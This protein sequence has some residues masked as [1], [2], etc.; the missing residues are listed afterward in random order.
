MKTIALKKLG[1]AAS[2]GLLFASSSAWSAEKLRYVVLVDGGKQAGEQVVETTDDGWTKVK[3]IFK[4]NGRGP[5]IEERYRLDKDGTFAEYYAKG[6]TTFGSSVD[7]S[8]V[9]K[10]TSAQWKSTAE[11]GSTTLKQPALYSPINASFQPAS[12]AI[13]LLSNSANGELN[14]L[15]GGTLRQS[16]VSELEVKK[17]SETRTIQLLKQTGQGLAPNFVWATKGKDA[18]LFAFLVPG[19]LTGIEEGWQANAPAMEKLQREAE[20]KVLKE[21]AQKA[22]KPLDGLAVIRNARVFDS[23]NAK[24]SEPSDVYVLRGVITS[25]MPANSPA[26]GVKYEV[27]A[28]GRVLLPGL[29]DMHGHV[30]QWD[31]AL[32][33]AAG[34]TTVRDMG[35]DNATLQRIMDQH[36]AGELLATHIVP[37]GFLEG[38]SP[39]SARNGFVI[40]NLQQAKDAI[41]WYAQHGYPQ[42]KIY[43]SFPKEILKETVEYAHSRGMRVSG[44]I[45]VFLR[46][47]DAVNA[48][49]DEI[50]HINQILLNFLVKPDTDTRT[51]ERFRLPADQ[52]ADLDFDS[53]PV[54]DYIALLKNKNVAVDPTLSTFEFIRQKDGVVSESYKDVIDHMPLELQRG[55]RSGSMKIPDE[56]TYQRYNKSYEKM[57]EFVGRMYK[58]GIPVVAGTDAISGFTLHSELEFYVKAGLTPAQ[59]LQIATLNGAKFSRT[60]S[61]RGQI[62]PGYL[63]DLVLVEGDPTKNIGD[64]RR[65]SWVFTQGGVVS[66]NQIYQMMGIKPFVQNPPALKMIETKSSDAPKGAGGRLHSHAHQHGLGHSQD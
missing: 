18:R 20:N 12:I 42:L 11:Q 17:D 7:D 27:D 44:H 40:S 9:R 63:A 15:P 32:N 39:Y 53:K 62:A 41:D 8:F 60:S 13:N 25:I 24:L 29:F 46:A 19:Y 65:I 50:Q 37:N 47:E 1:L 45:P 61:T 64:L 49:Y 16:V 23:V 21:F 34:V 4:D 36:K 51:L 3:F 26:Q 5:E 56:A 10:G 66:P 54:Q 22:I 55:F 59:A 14:L 6:S 28:A 35:N 48:G 52:V 38:E 43:N 2:I 31:G 33:L 58:A 57:V 30:S